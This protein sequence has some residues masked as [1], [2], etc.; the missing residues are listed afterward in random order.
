[1][2]DIKFIKN[3]SSLFD[4]ILKKRNILFSS[5]EILLLYQKYL[6]NLKKTQNLQEKKNSF[7]K[8]FSPKLSKKDLEKIKNDVAI[9]KSELDE[10][11]KITAEKEKKINQ[12]L[13]EIP[14]LVDERV[15]VG[16]SEND[17]VIIK[18]SGKIDKPR[19]NVK[20]HVEVLEKHNLLDLSLIHI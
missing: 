4:E 15:P 16:K 14:N 2:H 20:N 17:N 19:F 18:E 6:E 13:L 12:V 8:K 11:K 3:N 1:M 5:K 7:S 9:I 10:L